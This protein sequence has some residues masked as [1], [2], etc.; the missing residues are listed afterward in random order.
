[1]IA[2]KFLIDPINGIKMRRM[3]SLFEIFMV[4]MAVVGGL[5][6]AISRVIMLFVFSLVG[7]ARLDQNIFPE[8]I[9]NFIYLDGPQK[10]YLATI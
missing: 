1:M 8:F 9:N 6:S 10:T 5:L 7:L 3:W 4:Y 2:L